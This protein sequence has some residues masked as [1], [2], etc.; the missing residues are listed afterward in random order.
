METKNRNLSMVNGY[1]VLSGQKTRSTVKT[2]VVIN[3]YDLMFVF[4]CQQ[5]VKSDQFIKLLSVCTRTDI[6]LKKARS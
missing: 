1:Y 4:K 5:I 6:E 3:V 2:S